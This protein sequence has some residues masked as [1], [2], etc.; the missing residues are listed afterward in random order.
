M[1]P[2]LSRPA[3]PHR[4][5]LNWDALAQCEAGG[6]W[7]INTGN[8]YYG[9]L[10]FSLSTWQA[11]GGAGRPDQASR[12]EQIAVGERL[13][14]APA[15]RRGPSAAGTCWRRRDDPRLARQQPLEPA[16]RAMPPVQPHDAAA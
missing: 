3:R 12:D 11:N 9:G 4:V 10:Q 2:Q 5:G 1:P 15:H 8:G 6:N 16:R 13:Y 14:A 7:A